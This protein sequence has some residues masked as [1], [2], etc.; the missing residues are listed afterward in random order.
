MKRQ[1]GTVFKFTG[2]QNLGYFIE[3]IDGQLELT[4][5]IFDENYFNDV[6]DTPER[7]SLE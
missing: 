4:N 1:D 2:V 6:V 5:P 3:N 7:A